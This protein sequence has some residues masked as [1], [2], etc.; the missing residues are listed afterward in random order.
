M[1]TPKFTLGALMAK[2]PHMEAAKPKMA[3]VPGSALRLKR[4][5]LSKVRTGPGF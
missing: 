5:P 1:T 2:M 3:P 4:L